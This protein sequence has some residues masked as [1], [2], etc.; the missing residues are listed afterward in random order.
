MDSRL[1]GNDSGC[2][3]MAMKLRLLPP[4]TSL[5]GKR[6]LLRVD[7]NVPLTGSFA[8]EKALKLE[9][10]F[11]TIRNLAD[12]GA[13]V[14]M[15]TH[16]GRP[17]GRD[18][19]FSTE[20]LAHIAHGMSDIPIHFCGEALD[21]PAGLKKAQEMIHV[22]KP[23]TVFLL[24]NV[25]FLKGEE[26]DAPGIAKALASLGD[27]FV[28][29][30]F[31]ASHRAHASVVGVAKILPSFAGPSLAEEVAALSRLLEKPK[32]P[33]IA[34]VGGAKLSTKLGVLEA[35]LKV[36]DR[37]LVGGAMAHPFFV[38]K[39]I[40]IG[41]SFT[42]KGGAAI[43][44]KLM[45][46]PKLALPTDAVVAPK[47]DPKKAHV[48]PIKEIKANEVIGD[49]GTETMM[50]WAAWLKKANTIAWN[51]PVGVAEIPTFS[52]GSL[53]LARVIAS[54]SK[55]SCFG[56]VGG[57]DTLPI[58]AKSGMGEWFD[59][60]STGGGA[61]LEFIAKK[62]SL[63]G[64]RVLQEKPTKTKKTKKTTTTTTKKRK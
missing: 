42:E 31:A 52:H 37:V 56:V 49:I 7:W 36:A 18:M 60:V 51:G 63:P 43:A 13:V 50:T 39:G 12:R 38:A 27:I 33:Y 6:V 9:R 46:N 62:G 30:A 35:L 48:V 20:K 16:L 23:G 24:E 4:K 29:D 44:K 32:R 28:D 54:R 19:K 47:L 34:V 22:A 55:G 10:T 3:P 64:L 8:G 5:K 14:V 41:K 61:M 57:G 58:V 25:R 11:G 17:K 40:K 1:R 15:M 53:L 59:H 2:Y 45:R 21:T 26:T